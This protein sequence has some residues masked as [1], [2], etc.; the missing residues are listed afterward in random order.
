V[1]D[2]EHATE[3]LTF[4][5][6]EDRSK[7]DDA[8]AHHGILR[9]GIVEL[10]NVLQVYAIDMPFQRLEAGYGSRPFR[11]QCP[12]SAQEPICLCPL[13]AARIESRVPVGIRPGVI[14]D[15][16]V[17]SID[18]RQAVD[19]VPLRFDRLRGK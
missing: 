3:V 15:G 12:T 7:L 11:A 17:Y 2:G 4:Q 8:F 6:L 5:F 14:V 18:T 19:T 16:Y 13:I 10:N 1:L 9:L